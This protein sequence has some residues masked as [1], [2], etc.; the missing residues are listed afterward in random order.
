MISTILIICWFNSRHY[1]NTT[2]SLNIWLHYRQIWTLLRS[3]LSFSVMNRRIKTW[4]LRRNQVQNHHSRQTRKRIR[5]ITATT[6]GTAKKARRAREAPTRT[7][8]SHRSSKY[9][10]WTTLRIW[11]CA[12]TAS[13]VARIKRTSRMTKLRKSHSLT[14]IRRSRIFFRLLRFRSRRFMSLRISLLSSRSRSICRWAKLEMFRRD[15]TWQTWLISCSK[16][17]SS[18]TFRGHHSSQCFSTHQIDRCCLPTF[19]HQTWE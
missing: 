3:K 19:S 1:Y 4:S 12:T 18:R 10:A 6:A 9:Q 17:S 15:R 5:M 14:R 2:F 11:R 7:T 8:S 16:R 13:I